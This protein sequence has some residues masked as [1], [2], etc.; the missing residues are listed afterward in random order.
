[1]KQYLIPQRL[2]IQGVFTESF[3]EYKLRRKLGNLYANGTVAQ[4]ARIRADI[5]VDSWRKLSFS[6]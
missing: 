2:S 3:E 1:M 5:E 4:R 6:K